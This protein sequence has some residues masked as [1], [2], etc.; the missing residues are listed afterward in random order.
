MEGEVKKFGGM[1]ILFPFTR[2]VY[3]RYKTID[4]AEMALANG[5]RKNNRFYEL[6]RAK[7]IDVRSGE[8]CMS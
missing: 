3:G 1:E 7:I 6:D 8:E 4:S 5:L 2:Q